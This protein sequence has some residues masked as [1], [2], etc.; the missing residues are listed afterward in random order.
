MVCAPITYAATGQPNLHEKAQ[1]SLS[2]GTAMAASTELDTFTAPVVRG[3]SPYGK[4][5][6]FEQPEPMQSRDPVL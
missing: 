6:W 3:I 5:C 2:V 1:P 4:S